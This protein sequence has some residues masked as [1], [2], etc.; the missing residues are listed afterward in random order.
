MTR[1]IGSTARFPPTPFGFQ[2]YGNR[3]NK[4]TTELSVYKYSLGILNRVHRK[5]IT[6]STRLTFLSK[7][8]RATVLLQRAYAFQEAAHIIE[9][10]MEVLRWQIEK[11]SN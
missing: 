1:R 9:E 7:K 6:K 2:D 5:L 4:M 8:R 11:I 3:I 10:E